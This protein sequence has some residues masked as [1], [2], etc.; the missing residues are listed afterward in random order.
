MSLS[1]DSNSHLVSP[2]PEVNEMPSL[3]KI[4]YLRELHAA[5]E[6]GSANMSDFKLSR[7]PE[8]LTDAGALTDLDVSNNELRQL[9]ATIA[10]W[11]LLRRLNLENNHI[12][13]LEPNI[14]CCTC[15]EELYLNNNHIRR[16]PP[17]MG[18]LTAL[19]VLDVG[20]QYNAPTLDSVGGTQGYEWSAYPTLVHHV[21]SML[22][23]EASGVFARIKMEARVPCIA[24]MEDG[25]LD[26]GSFAFTACVERLREH[27][28]AERDRAARGEPSREE[29]TVRCR[30]CGSVVVLSL[31]QQYP[32]LRSDNVRTW[33]PSLVYHAGVC[34][35]V[36]YVTA[37][38]LLFTYL[39][40]NVSV[41]VDATHGC[42]CIVKIC[43]HA[44]VCI[45]GCRCA[46]VNVH[47]ATIYIYIY[48]YIYVCMY[49]YICIHLKIQN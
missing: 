47:H 1:F 22:C 15:L 3:V 17:E 18:R 25:R 14:G 21:H 42:L 26:A 7:L 46:F 41:H 34:M 4:R 31:L 23:L 10:R 43:M 24:C 32:K 36:L 33:M 49:I 48:I 30:V 40:T 2:P 9:P 27:Q 38:V 19:T 20:R 45:G 11:K 16:L 8:V 12:E 37:H 5:F 13:T 39:G 6:H 28:R 29:P 35:C 44:C